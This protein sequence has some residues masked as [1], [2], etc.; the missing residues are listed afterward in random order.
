MWDIKPG[1]EVVCVNGDWSYPKDGSDQ[2][3]RCPTEGTTYTVTEVQIGPVSGGLF[4]GLEEFDDVFLWNAE[5][6][7]KAQ[8]RDLHAWLKTATKFEEPTRAPAVEP[9]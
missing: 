4:V 2:P 1:D 9:A 3:E 8:R 7:R 6:F 5:H